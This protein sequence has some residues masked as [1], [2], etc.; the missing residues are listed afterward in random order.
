VTEERKP[1][2]NRRQGSVRD[3]VGRNLADHTILRNT[4]VEEHTKIPKIFSVEYKIFFL[5]LDHFNI[6]RWCRRDVS[7]YFSHL[8]SISPPI[9]L[10]LLSHAS[11][12][13]KFKKS[14]V[15]SSSVASV[16]VAEAGASVTVTEART[17]CTT[18]VNLYVYYE[19]IK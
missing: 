13:K 16:L 3:D 7:S 14:S 12:K 11:K 6:A 19:S 5:S 2:T 8:L 9:I 15:P 1:K 4:K 10:N 18:E 17:E